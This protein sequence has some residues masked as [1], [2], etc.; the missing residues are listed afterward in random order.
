M[1]TVGIF[2]AKTKFSELVEQVS[3]S[4]QSITVTNRGKPVVDIT[5]TR[6][7]EGCGMTREEAFLEIAVSSGIGASLWIH[8]ILEKAVSNHLHHTQPVV[9]PIGERK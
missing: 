4:G 2:D 3:S 9:R 1:K 7:T 6:A 5:P 8:C